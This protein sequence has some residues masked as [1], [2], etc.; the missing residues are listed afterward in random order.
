LNPVVHIYTTVY[1]RSDFIYWVKRSLDH[2]LEEPFEL[3]ALDNTPSDQPKLV[4]EI[5][6]ECRE[7]GV[8]CERVPADRPEGT[9]YSHAQALEWAWK[10]LVPAQEGRYV[11]F[12]D[13]DMFLVRPFS[14][15][16]A[17]GIAAVAGVVQT[18]GPYIYPWPGLA[19]FHLD[20][21]PGREEA[22][23]MPGEIDGVNTDTGGAFAR[24]LKAHPQ[25]QLQGLPE[26]AW[27][28]RSAGNLDRLPGECRESYDDEYL[29]IIVAGAFLHYT[30]GSLWKPIHP[31]VEERKRYYAFNLVGGCLEGRYELPVVEE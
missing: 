24:Y 1:G 13:F 27:I 30:N 16:E 26:T 3:V 4:E 6:R 15:V 25:V 28:R 17:L 18:R 9:S 12:L 11:M 5:S 31:E 10:N 20:R 22:G 21:L 7:H 29:M 2:F 8:R 19:I 14:V 23:F